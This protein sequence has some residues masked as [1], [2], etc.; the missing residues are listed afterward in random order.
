MEGEGILGTDERNRRE[1]GPGAGSGCSRSDME[2]AGTRSDMDLGGGDK[3]WSWKEIGMGTSPGRRRERSDKCH[4][5]LYS[6][7][8]VLDISNSAPKISGKV[9]SQSLSAP[10]PLQYYGDNPNPSS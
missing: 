7:N 4:I 5:M 9:L 8:Q 3:A 10:I 2:L 6:E 1:C